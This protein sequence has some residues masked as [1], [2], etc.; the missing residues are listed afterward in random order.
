MI[1][2]GHNGKM[3]ATTLDSARVM[4]KTS[5]SPFHSIYVDSS[6]DEGDTLYCMGKMLICD[7]QAPTSDVWY[8]IHSGGIWNFYSY[9]VK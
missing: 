4:T 1:L 5:F 2:Y 9:V 7:K 8:C 3:R 6:E